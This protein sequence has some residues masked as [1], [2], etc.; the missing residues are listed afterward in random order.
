MR[1]QRGLFLF[2]VAV[3]LHDNVYLRSVV[4]HDRYFS[5]VRGFIVPGLLSDLKVSSLNNLTQVS[6]QKAGANLGHRPDF[7]SLRVQFCRIL[8]VGALFEV[9]S[10]GAPFLA[11]CVRSGMGEQQVPP[12]AG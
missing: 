10:P 3:G 6:A 11:F 9:G 8:L 2:V 7:D 1:K 12:R 4:W 5:S